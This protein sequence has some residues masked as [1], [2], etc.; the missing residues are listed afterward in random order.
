MQDV[1]EH[2]GVSATTVSHVINDTRPVSNELRE[3]VLT[4]I[5][6]LDY[7]PNSLARSL[8]RGR[9][10]TIGM[11]IPTGV[12]PYFAEIAQGV[13]DTSFEQGYSVI[14]CNSKNSPD[15]AEA[16]TDVLVEKQVDGILLAS[17]ELSVER[18]RTLQA[19]H[20]PLVVVNRD[21]SGSRT[22]SIMV[23]HAH[24]SYLGTRHL[25]ELGHRRIGCVVGRPDLTPSAERIAGY[26]QALCEAG[27]PVDERLVLGDGILD[28]EGG[29]HTACQ[30]M[31]MSPS[32]TAILAGND[33]MA[34]GVIRAAREMG[35]NVPG[36][37]SVI[38]FDDVT[39]AS[40]SIP[41]LTTVFQPRYEIGVL[42]AELLIERMRD[43]DLPPRHRN[44]DVSL[45][46][47]QS[48]APPE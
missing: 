35:R 38:G 10:H 23:D 34:V 33:L 30:L 28:F 1:A 24:G 45:M 11:I 20:M 7:R 26:R 29:Y 43:P 40:Y 6:E 31:A 41:P 27:I 4:A 19:Q 25:I 44:L 22:D 15:R 39:L 14:L 48:T 8:R 16:Y 2:A 3:R 21:I 42:A 37:L 18:V 36:D 9:T 12:N 13:E 47:R 17:I 46:V 32:P 5:D